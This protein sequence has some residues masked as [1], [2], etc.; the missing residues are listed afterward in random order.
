MPRQLVVIFDFLQR[1]GWPA[2]VGDEHRATG[3]GAFSGPYIAGEVSTR[4]G[5]DRH[6]TF[7]IDAVSSLQH[8]NICTLRH[9]RKGVNLEV[10]C[11]AAAP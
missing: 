1:K 7:L 3:G 6:D 9:V 2:T 4:V 8:K 5:A 11:A 10:L